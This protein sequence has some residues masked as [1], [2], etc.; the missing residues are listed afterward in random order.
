[1][2]R[3]VILGCGHEGLGV[4]AGTIARAMLLGCSFFHR[5]LLEESLFG[6]IL[7]RLPMFSTTRVSELI[8]VITGRCLINRARKRDFKPPGW[9]FY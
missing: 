9:G 5:V 2:E 1:M 6:F 3:F 8:G 7:P 4:L